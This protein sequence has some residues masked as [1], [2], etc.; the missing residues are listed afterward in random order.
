MLRVRHS[1]SK[2]IWFFKGL[3]SFNQTYSRLQTTAWRS[4]LSLNI[5]RQITIAHKVTWAEL[6]YR[7]ACVCG[8]DL[9]RS[10]EP[11]ADSIECIKLIESVRFKKCDG[12]PL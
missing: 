5:T 8:V 7:S 1:R 10:A 12:T 9:S 4:R 2:K 11:N 6:R 3:V